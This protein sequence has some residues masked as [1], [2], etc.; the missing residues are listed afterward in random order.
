MIHENMLVCLFLWTGTP[1]WTRAPLIAGADGDTRHCDAGIAARRQF[2]NSFRLPLPRS[3]RRVD[4]TWRSAG[5]N[6]AAFVMT[7]DRV[8]SSVA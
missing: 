6:F 2:K 3:I 1:Q 4:P 8:F 7:G 5:I